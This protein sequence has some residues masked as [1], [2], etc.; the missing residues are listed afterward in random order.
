MSFV[1]LGN[2]LWQSTIFAALVGLAT[3][4]LRPNRAAVRHALW[5]TAS[6]KFLVP[7]AA[8]VALGQQIA[9]RAPARVVYREVTIVVD[10]VS[11]PLARFDAAPSAA[12]ARRASA[13]VATAAPAIAGTLW[14]AGVVMVVTVWWRRWRT[15][16]AIARSGMPLRSGPALE[17]LRRIER[18]RGITR[19]ISLVASDAP[20]EPGVFGVFRPLLVWPTTIAQ[21]LDAAHIETVLAHEVAHVRRRDNLTAAVHMAV[22]TLFWFHPLVWWIGG[23]LVDERERACDEE[24]LR[25]GSEP[26]VYAET[27][28][29]SCR[30]FVESPLPCVAGVTGSN[31]AKRIERIMRHDGAQQLTGWKKALVGALIAGPIVAPIAVGAAAPR[32]RVSAS[33]T[34]ARLLVPGDAATFRVRSGDQSPATFEVASVRPN[35]SGDAKA[36]IQV[37][38]GGRFTATGV[39]LRQLIRNAYQLQDFQIAGGPDW[40]A[41]DRFDI[42]AKAE[43]ADGEDPF[44]AEKLGQPSRVQLMLRLL[45]ADRFS[46]GVHADSKE[47]PIYALTLARRDGA[48]GPQL[49]RSTSACDH[50]LADAVVQPAK[51]AAFADVP[52]CGM[53]VLPGTIVGGGATIPQLAT[54]LSTLVGRIVRDQTG[55]SDDFEFTLRWTPEQIPEGYVKKAAAMRLP[56]IDPEGASLFTALREQLGLTLDSEKGPVD[57]LV[58]DRAEKPHEN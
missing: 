9:V 21:H 47:L 43:G 56:P 36:M 5:M 54:A 22:E 34:N 48:V 8:V 33:I 51:G 18:A 2:H 49:R 53:R 39:T 3:L 12:A 45:L 50:P 37:L 25:A 16:A 23:R 46:L 17:A 15:V 11:A 14:A 6:I 29:K 20:I 32:S 41:A 55:L 30:A 4:A 28:L 24:V 31:L 42:V 10:R 19:P 40:L 7:V 35:T 26:R 13:L 38:P 57:I 1:A 44:R 27:I 52:P 58:V